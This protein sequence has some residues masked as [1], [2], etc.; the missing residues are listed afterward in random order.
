M[1]S[2]S[3]LLAMMTS[4]VYVRREIRGIGHEVE[5]ASDWRCSEPVL[6]PRLLDDRRAQSMPPRRVGHLECWRLRASYLLGRVS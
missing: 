1:P 5:A 3:G 4:A 6:D 2:G